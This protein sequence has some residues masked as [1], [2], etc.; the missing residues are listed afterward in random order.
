MA[1]TS[2]AALRKKTPFHVSI[3]AKQTT[4]SL[5]YVFPASLSRRS[6]MLNA[7]QV[8]AIMNGNHGDPFAFL[9]MH[10]DERGMLLV[11]TLQPG[12]QRVGVV[13]VKSGNELA[14]LAQIHPG[15]FF[16]GPIPRRH[17]R[18]RYRLRVCWDGVNVDVEDPYR[19][20][21]VLGE[22]DVW[23][24][25]EGTHYRP[26]QHLG[27]HRRDFEGVQGSSFA[28]WAPSATRVSIVGEFNHWDGR[29]HPM[30]L[31]R[32]CGVWEIFLPNVGPGVRY[33]VRDQGT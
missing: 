5:H 24:L 3:F 4:R 28:V 16:S 7:E 21:P 17:N 10:E 19:F 23:L 15:G 25:A 31:R 33:R 20:P 12:A 18:F 9:G 1:T 14:E 29:R 8:T 26:Y 32:E 30:R 6:H 27:A 11:R 2:N 22:M 13:D